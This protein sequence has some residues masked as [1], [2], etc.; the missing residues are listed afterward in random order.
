MIEPCAGLLEFAPP[1]LDALLRTLQLLE[2]QAIARLGNVELILGK[3][4]RFDQRSL[5]ID[6]L[7]Q[8]RIGLGS[9]DCHAVKLPPLSKSEPLSALIYHNG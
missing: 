8:E 6:R 4:F 3:R 9:F 5:G 1:A 2:R 7:T